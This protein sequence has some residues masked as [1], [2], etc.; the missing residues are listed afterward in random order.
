MHSSSTFVRISGPIPEIKKS[1][2]I[3]DLENII[4]YWEESEQSKALASKLAQP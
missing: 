4:A 2:L 1:A 3:N